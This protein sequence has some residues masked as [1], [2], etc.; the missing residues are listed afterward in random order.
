MKGKSRL[1]E[2]GRSGVSTDTAMARACQTVNSCL[3]LQLTGRPPVTTVQTRIRYSPSNSPLCVV[4][5]LWLTLVS[6]WL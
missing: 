2:P 3:A 6:I 4:V 5:H 1:W